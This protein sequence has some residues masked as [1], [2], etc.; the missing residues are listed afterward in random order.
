MTIAIQ[1][2]DYG[3]GDASSPIWSRLL[4]EAGHQVRTVDVYRADILE[5]LEGCDAF[6]WRHVHAPHMR[7]VARRLLPVVER[8]LGLTV[9]PDQQTC[10]HYDDKIA[11]SHLLKAAGIPIPR[12]WVWY[13][14]G[15]ALAWAAQA[16]YPVVLK[17][18]SG[19]G[20]TNVRLVSS[21]S[22]AVHWI[23]RLFG[24]GV[25]TLDETPPVLRH[26]V[27]HALRALLALDEPHPWELHKDYVLFQEFLPGNDYDTRVTIIGNRAFGYRRHNRPGDFRASGSGNFSVEPGLITPEAVRLAFRVAEKLGTQSVALDLL[28]RDGAPVVGEISYTY[29]S[30]MVHSCPGH[31]D[32][33]LNWHPGQMWPEQAQIEDLLA[34]LEERTP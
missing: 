33:E 25:E 20:S 4:S 14:K 26:R 6:M 28:L 30:W 8:E 11:Q 13:D 3:P 22:E 17:L 9:Y 7:Q 15:A 1:P 24:H 27:K 21:A 34:R 18:W 32:G 31:W 19:A 29:V 2:D 16:C 12:T 10:W 5:Q 23:E